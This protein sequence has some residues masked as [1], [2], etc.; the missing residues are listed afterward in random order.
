MHPPYS[1]LQLL[2]LPCPHYAQKLALSLSTSDWKRNR[3]VSTKWL[4]V[5][6]SVYVGG[7]LEMERKRESAYQSLYLL[8]LCVSSSFSSPS[9]CPH[10]PSFSPHLV[11]H[12]CSFWQKLA[13]LLPQPPHPA[14]SA[15]VFVILWFYVCGGVFIW[16]SPIDSGDR[17][18]SYLSLFS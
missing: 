13:I 5:E 1:K 18:P 14:S 16:G 10:L 6:D 3:P 15:F 8:Y 17:D 12:L 7:W 9:F 4:P 11:L 2:N